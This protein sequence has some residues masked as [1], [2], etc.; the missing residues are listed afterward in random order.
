MELRTLGTTGIEVSPLC[1][2][3]FYEDK[4]A[5]AAVSH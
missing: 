1:L 4:L 3:R 2:G 5:A